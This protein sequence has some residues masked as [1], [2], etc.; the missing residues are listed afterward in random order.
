MRTLSIGLALCCLVAGTAFAQPAEKEEEKEPWRKVEGQLAYRGRQA[1]VRVDRETRRVRVS[2]RAESGRVEDP[3]QRTL[4]R[5][6]F[7]QLELAI[8]RA[9]PSGWGEIVPSSSE[10]TIRRLQ[11][12]LAARGYPTS[13]SGVY[14]AETRAAVAAFQGHQFLKV[15]GR[16]SQATRQRLPLPPPGGGYELDDEVVKGQRLAGVLWAIVHSVVSGQEPVRSQL[17]ARVVARS[18]RKVELSELG[19]AARREA[20]VLH[21]GYQ[22]ALER[23]EEGTFEL[24]TWRG[25]EGDRHV[26]TRIH[27]AA[28]EGAAAGLPAERP[29]EVVGLAGEAGLLLMD[30]KGAKAP[31]TRPSALRA[32]N[33]RAAADLPGATQALSGLGRRP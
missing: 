33:L 1:S 27:V 10:A 15:T 16:A 2:L 18:G 4:S 8:E 23:L 6:L 30:S 25:E 12:R 26:I 5:E 13:Q 3:P 31:N 7:A 24:L 14:D 9:R 20:Y 32:A 22:S 21:T 17:R 28:P 11:E 29:L 19:G